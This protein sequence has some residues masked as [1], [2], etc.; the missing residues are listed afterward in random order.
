MITYRRLALA[1]LLGTATFAVQAQPVTYTLD[2]SHTSVIAT[3]V[4]MGMSHPSAMF[5]GIK[6]TLVY[7]PEHPERSS[8]EAS[9]PIASAHTASSALDEHFQG[10]DFFDAAKYPDAVFKS[11]RVER[12]AAPDQLKV[13]GN[14]TVHGITRPV[15]LDVTV[16][17]VGMHPMMKVPAAGFNA[18]VT[19]NR[20]DYGVK[21]Y[22][23]MVSDAIKLD[24]TTE[25]F[26]EKQPQ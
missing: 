18:S 16:G 20:S 25:A 6:G 21:L 1:A 3:W 24:I 8:V 4:H 7:D 19:I 26:A 22:V 5:T 2:P 17:K 13:T 10:A 11:T 9:V 12:G 15:T 23:P 14:L